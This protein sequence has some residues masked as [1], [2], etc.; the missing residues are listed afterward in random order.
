ME[1]LRHWFDGVQQWLFENLMQPLMFHAGL[2][3]LLESGYEASGWVLVGLL[4]LAFI[5]AVIGGLQRWRPVEKVTDHATITTDIV[6]TLVHRLGVFR[7]ALFLAV[8]PWVDSLFGALRVA[9]FST[10]QLDGILPG[11]T[12][13]PWV[14]LLLYLVAFDLVDYWIHRGQHHFE[15]WWRLHSLHHAQRQMTMWSDN[16]FGSVHVFIAFTTASNCTTRQSIHLMRRVPVC[17]N[18]RSMQCGEGTILGCFCLGGT[19]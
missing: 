18:R 7:L 17:R 9:G 8:D 1:S 6:Y 11:V 2:G 4:Q 5:V 19:C 12:D 15:W 10:F 13:I 14:S 16:G 3:N